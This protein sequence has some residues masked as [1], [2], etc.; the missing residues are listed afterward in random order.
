MIHT[1]LKDPRF[2]PVSAEPGDDAVFLPVE[3]EAGTVHEPVC[4]EMPPPPS[5]APLSAS[6]VDI[7]LSD[8]RRIL[9]EGPTALTAVVSL[10]QGLAV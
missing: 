5:S 7:T 2:A 6:R 4:Q 9:I 3:I 10:V 1:W 8:G